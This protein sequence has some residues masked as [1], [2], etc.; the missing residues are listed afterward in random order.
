MKEFIN[1]QFDKLVMLFLTLIFL[2]ALLINKN[3]DLIETLQLLTTGSFSSLVTLL[4]KA[5]MNIP[6][7]TTITEQSDNKGSS[8]TETKTEIK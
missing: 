7:T 1:K 8:T 2:A 4:T 5:L 3:P 6:S